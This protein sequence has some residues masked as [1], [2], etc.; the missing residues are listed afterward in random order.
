ME[1][2]WHSFRPL[3]KVGAVIGGLFLAVALAFL[4]G[5][6]VMWLWNWLM[7]A[8][9]GLGTIS[10]WQAWGLVLLAHLLFKVGGNHHDSSHSREDHWKERFRRRFSS[11]EGEKNEADSGVEGTTPQEV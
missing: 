3:W 7:P 6:F 11:K 4:F 9:F 8:I 1:R 5:V 10:Y 2:K